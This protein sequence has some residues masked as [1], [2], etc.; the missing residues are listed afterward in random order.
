MGAPRGRWSALCS[1]NI[2]GKAGGTVLASLNDTRLLHFRHKYM[3]DLRRPTCGSAAR[4]SPA[5]HVAVNTQGE[6]GGHGV[7]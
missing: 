7:K 2:I 5:A 6:G 1:R 4:A 3:R